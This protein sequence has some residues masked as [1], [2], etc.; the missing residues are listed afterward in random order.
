MEN[1]R[2]SSLIAQARRESG[3]TQSVFASRAGTSQP[4]IARYEAGLASPSINTLVRI[5]KAGGL[6]LELRVKATKVVNLSS[7]RAKKIR[8]NRGEINRLMKIAGAS[9][10][11]IFGSVVRGEDTKSSDIDFLVDFDISQ[12]LVPIVKLKTALSA[13]LK[14]KVDVAPASLLKKSV[15]ENA[16]KEAVPL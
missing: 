15:L 13:L 4:A 12:G 11:R 16:L 5:L 1:Q 14:E 6:E 10:V 3:L 2:S 8:K 7:R 9:H